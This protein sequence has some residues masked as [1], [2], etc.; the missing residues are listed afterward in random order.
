MMQK[1]GKAVAEVVVAGAVEVLVLVRSDSAA[2]Y[3]SSV[4]GLM[5]CL[6]D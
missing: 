4:V 1:D 3:F 2:Y 6:V 5:G